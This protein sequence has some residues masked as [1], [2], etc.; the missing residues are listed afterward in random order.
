MKYQLETKKR[1]EGIIYNC[2]F[3]GEDEL[4]EVDTSLITDMRNMFN[5]YHYKAMFGVDINSI[6]ENPNVDISEWDLSNVTDMNRMFHSSKFD[7]D[8]SKWILTLNPNIDM[9]WFNIGS[10]HEK[11]YG[12]ISSYEDFIRIVDWDVVKEYIEDIIENRSDNEKYKLLKNIDRLKQYIDVDI[13]LE[14]L[15]KKIETTKHQPK[16]KDELVQLIVDCYYGDVYLKDIDTS[17]I[18][19]MSGIF[20]RAHGY[21]CDFPDYKDV[22]II[23]DNPENDISDWDVSN[24]T[25]MSHLFQNS[26]FSG[27]I[28]QWD[29]S[30]VTSMFEMFR[31]SRFNGDISKWDVSNV[32]DMTQ[33]F[34]SSKFNQNISLW[35]VSKVT[36][37]FEMF[38]GSEFN[39]NI[40]LWDVS[41][42]SYMDRMF[43]NSKF[44]KD[45]YLWTFKLKPGVTLMEFNSNSPHKELYP[46]INRYQSFVE[47]RYAYNSKLFK[48]HIHEILEQGSE[49]EKYK[50]LQQLQTFKDE[51]DIDMDNLANDLSYR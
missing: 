4:N 2:S 36:S 44:S 38:R 27:D 16:T 19:D 24:V 21:L 23:W 1:L 46:Y 34:Y 30:S 9:L 20:N 48:Q 47:Y 35:D 18:T 37:M 5:Y 14:Q 31:S 43:M 11:K 45:L 17:L 50:L 10:E 7:G 22:D 15:K 8:L 6:W 39:Q 28:S 40:S 25:D 32:T 3:G 12:K 29:V 41:N 42:V 26:T 49:I 13:D 33:M 51:I